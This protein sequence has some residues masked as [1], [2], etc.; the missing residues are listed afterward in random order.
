MSEALPWQEAQ[1]R[2]MQQRRCAGRLPHALLLSG[3]S[4]LGKGQFA[5][6]LAQGLLCS[7]PDAG[8]DACGQCRSC[9]LFVAGS[10]PDYRWVQPAEEG[11]A[12]KV[13]QIRDLCAFLGYTP[14]Y[15]GYQIA[16][17]EPADQ[18][19][20]NAANSLLKT[21]E[22]PPGQCL[23]LL[24]TARSVR[25]PVTVRSRCQRLAF[26]PPPAEVAM[27]WVQARVVGG[28]EVA[29]LLA[30]VGGAPL[31]ALAGADG[32]RWQRR[33]ELAEGYEQVM[34]GRLDPIRA[35]E[36]WVRGDLAEQLR[37]L[38][39]WQMDVIRL[40]MSPDP[41]H[42]NNPDLRAL[43]HGWAER[44]SRCRL[45]DRWDAALRLYTLC[46]TTQVRADLLLEAF[47]G[48]VATGG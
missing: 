17:L 42:L 34:T 21:L 47:F 5:R 29:A 38:L 24:V 6:R 44:Y 28:V 10:H 48:D 13:D 30:T 2:H 14:Q 25:L 43:L 45:V 37:W 3:P 11:T 32:E 9:R 22:E 36:S 39:S 18:L 41:P 33:Q 35:A 7:A 31:A 40:K 46:T 1:W 23:L 20:L 12:I 27:P 16:V 19:N 8:G 26:S 4:G 15:G